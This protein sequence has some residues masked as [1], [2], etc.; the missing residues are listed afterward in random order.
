MTVS[1]PAPVYISWIVWGVVVAGLYLLA[2]HRRNGKSFGPFTKEN[3]Y[4]EYRKHLR[5][6]GRMERAAYFLL[7]LLLA[8]ATL[9]LILF[10]EVKK[11]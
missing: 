1:L 6:N 3:E 4:E 10:I 2:R 9:S 8:W 5:S 11:S 7:L